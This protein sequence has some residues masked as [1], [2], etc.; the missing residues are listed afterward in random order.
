MSSPDPAH[1]ATLRRVWPAIVEKMGGWPPEP[2]GVIT[3]G[4]GHALVDGRY[5][6]GL[7]SQI[8]QH[9]RPHYQD[10][11]DPTLPGGRAGVLAWLGEPTWHI[12]ISRSPVWPPGG[13]APDE[14]V[15]EELQEHTPATFIAAVERWRAE[16]CA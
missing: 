1:L 2:V 5:R 8:I 15:T 12:E 4:D 3:G 11:P 14:E 7:P 16:R 13:G 6:E 10:V 9:A